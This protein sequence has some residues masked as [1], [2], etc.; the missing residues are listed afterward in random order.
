MHI[1]VNS[2]R[3]ALWLVFCLFRH[4]VVLPAAFGGVIL[5]AWLVFGHPVSDLNDQLQKEATAWRTA[6]PG[7]YMWEDCPVPANAAPPLAKQAACTVTAV[8]T[9]TVVNNYLLALRAVW[10]VFLFLSNVLYVLS[11]LLANALNYH[12]QP[13][14][15]AGAAKGTYTRRADGKIIKE[16]DDE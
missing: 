10:I 14:R 8:T 7:H 13:C 2:L 9:E 16:A 6:P 11:R 1:I 15:E 5:L 3:Y 12:S 4:A